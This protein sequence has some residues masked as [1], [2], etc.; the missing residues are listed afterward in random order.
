MK[1]PGLQSLQ[2]SKARDNTQLSLHIKVL[3]VL[4]KESGYGR[5]TMQKDCAVPSYHVECLMVNSLASYPHHFTHF[6]FLL[7][8]NVERMLILP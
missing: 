2:I 8:K 1:S 6:L 5:E 7:Q 3:S 4:I